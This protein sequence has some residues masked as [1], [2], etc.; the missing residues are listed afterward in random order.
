MTE[1]QPVGT[2]SEHQLSVSE[3]CL[4]YRELSYSRMTEKQLVGTNS[5]HQVSVL[6]RYLAYRE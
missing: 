2:N 1:K 3:R 6:E 5:E 4:A